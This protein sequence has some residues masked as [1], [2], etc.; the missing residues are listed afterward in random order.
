MHISAT[1]IVVKAKDHRAPSVADAY[2]QALLS[3][4]GSKDQLEYAGFIQALSFLTQAPSTLTKSQFLSKVCADSVRRCASDGKACDL[5]DFTKYC[6]A[7]LGDPS[8]EVIKFMSSKDQFG[9]E[10]QQEE[11]R[12][13]GSQYVV[14]ILHHS[15]IFL[16]LGFV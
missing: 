6:D 11:L 3:D 12:R 7:T 8:A 5:N 13:D 1:S 4:T 16:K 15:D 9:Q 2:K 14:S 10:L